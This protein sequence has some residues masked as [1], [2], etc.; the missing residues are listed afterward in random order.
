MLRNYPQSVLPDNRRSLWIYPWVWYGLEPNNTVKLNWTSPR[1]SSHFFRGRV[2]SEETVN[3]ILE[4]CSCSLVYKP[5]PTITGGWG[6]AREKL[7]SGPSWIW[8]ESCRLIGNKRSTIWGEN[9]LQAQNNFT[10]V[11]LQLPGRPW[12]W[13][14]DDFSHWARVWRTQGC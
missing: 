6:G 13:M 8:A 4:G 14:E 9:E 2:Y 7:N 12:K 10:C 5:E 11:P 1:A 3:Q